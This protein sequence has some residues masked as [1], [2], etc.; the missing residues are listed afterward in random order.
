MN[1][2]IRVLKQQRREA[3]LKRL[4]AWGA[5]KGLLR[6][7][8]ETGE[9]SYRAVCRERTRDCMRRKRRSL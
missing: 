2:M 6:Y 4:V 1:D 3:E 5:D 8:A 7:P 9:D